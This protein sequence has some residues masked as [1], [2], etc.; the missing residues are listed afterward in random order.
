MTSKLNWM[1]T[2]DLSEEELEELA[3]LQAEVIASKTARAEF[4]DWLNFG[5]GRIT[6]LEHNQEKIFEV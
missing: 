6:D 4:R 1:V 5:P 3:E 2:V